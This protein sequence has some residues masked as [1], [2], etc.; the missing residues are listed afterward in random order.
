M[1][2]SVSHHYWSNV[3]LLSPTACTDAHQASLS[4]ITFTFGLLADISLSP[5]L[6]YIKNA[7]GVASAPLEILITL[8]YWSLRAID[9]KLVVPEFA[10]P[11]APIADL[12]FHLVP[13]A[14]MLIDV[15]FFSPPWTISTLPAIGLSSTIAVTYWFWVEECQKHNGYYPYP[16]FDAAGHNGRLALFV[17]SAVIMSAGTMALSRTYGLVNGREIPGHVKKE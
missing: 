14:V 17:M 8:L 6:F 9:P 5:K 12:G 15:M 2:P 4:T 1:A 11:L 13:S 10:P 16:L 3:S 7:L